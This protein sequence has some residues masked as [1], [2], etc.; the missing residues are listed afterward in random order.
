VFAGVAGKIR[1]RKTIRSLAALIDGSPMQDMDLTEAAARALS[2]AAGLAVGRHSDQIEPGDLLWALVAEESRAAEILVEGGLT[3]ADLESL[4]P[5]PVK[6][7]GDHP[8]ASRS[9]DVEV[10][11]FV[12]GTP[13]VRYS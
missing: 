12:S 7:E 3:T 11:P 8:E 4:G 13:S 9:A 10:V 1:C 6:F 2:A 5:R